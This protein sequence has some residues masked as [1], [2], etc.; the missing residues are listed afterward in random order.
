MTSYGGE[1]PWR[2]AFLLQVGMRVM[3]CQLIELCPRGPHMERSES[4][5]QGIRQATSTR[6]RR[7]RLKVWLYGTSSGARHR[8]GVAAFSGGYLSWALQVNRFSPPVLEP[9]LILSPFSQLSHCAAVSDSVNAFPSQRAESHEPPAAYRR[10]CELGHGGP[11][12]LPGRP[13]RNGGGRGVKFSGPLI[14][15]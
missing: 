1:I 4:K 13:G 7:D 8:L 14:C 15:S 2:I 5:V 12:A 6:D 3:G 10:P 11:G 9:R